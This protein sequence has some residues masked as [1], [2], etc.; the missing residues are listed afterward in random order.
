MFDRVDVIGESA[1]P[2]FKWLKKE[3]PGLLDSEAIKWNFIKFIVGKDGKVIEG[4][5]SSTEPANMTH[6]IESSLGLSD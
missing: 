2:L 6:S 5:A 1:E 3:A 4:I